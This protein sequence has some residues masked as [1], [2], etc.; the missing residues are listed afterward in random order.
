MEYVEGTPLDAILRAHGR[1]PLVSTATGPD[2]PPGALGIAMQLCDALEVAHRR[3]V[4]HRDIKPANVLVLRDHAIKL[5][6]FGIAK[7]TLEAATDQLTL[8]TAIV[9]TPYYASPEQVM[10]GPLDGRA[11][12]YALG[13]LLYQMIVGHVPID[14]PDDHAIFLA[15][16]HTPAPPLEIPDIALPRDLVEL[17]A[18]MLA[19]NRN[20]RPA[21]AA[22]VR[23]SLAAIAAVAPTL[24]MAPISPMWEAP[25]VAVH[26]VVNPASHG[27]PPAAIEARAPAPPPTLLAPAPPTSRRRPVALIAAL[28]AAA[29][30]GVGGTLL[31][32]RAKPGA[33]ARS[34]P[35][36]GATASSQRIATPAETS[37]SVP[38]VATAPTLPPT[39]T[40]TTSSQPI[41]PVLAPPPITTTGAKPRVEPSTKAPTP[42]SASAA[43]IAPPKGPKM[44]TGTEDRE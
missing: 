15:Q 35:T 20:E 38:A 34:E 7:R 36:I 43:P 37:M 33:E 32:T 6:D 25:T 18:R 27:P 13:I 3:G 31:L 23:A 19:K 4:V 44:G 21:D 9:G 17:V 22:Q 5:L 28:V 8:K 1:L 10:G 29:A 16:L 30:A 2:T 24:R 39:A 40:S 14:G 41:S 11:D 12:L 26:I 42:P